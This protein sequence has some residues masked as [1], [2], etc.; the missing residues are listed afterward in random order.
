M[1][2]KY[3]ILLVILIILESFLTGYFFKVTLDTL[4][5]CAIIITSLIQFFLFTKIS[6]YSHK[7]KTNEIR[8]F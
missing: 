7:V 8:R 2:Y 4:E 6:K 5:M 3:F 1:T